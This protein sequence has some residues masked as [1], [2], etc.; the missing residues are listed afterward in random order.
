MGRVRHPKLPRAKLPEKSA[1]A[2]AD[3]DIRAKTVNSLNA[4]GTAGAPCTPP[5]HTHHAACKPGAGPHG[6]GSP[7]SSVHPSLTSALQRGP[8]GLSHASPRLPHR[9][10]QLTVLGY[11]D[12]DL[13]LGFGDFLNCPVRLE[14]AS[15]KSP[16]VRSQGDATGG[17]GGT[18]CGPRAPHWEEDS[19]PCSRPLCRNGHSAAS[20]HSRGGRWAPSPAH[21][22]LGLATS[23]EMSPQER[24]ETVWAWSSGLV[25]KCHV[26]S[27]S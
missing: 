6:A 22:R 11:A 25:V 12:E 27:P 16:P 2:R 24:T 23:N 5:R 19:L 10:L 17:P 15:R 26:H 21:I 8:L 18:R 3:A 20:T 1:G 9:L 7:L 13:Q 14:N 4:D